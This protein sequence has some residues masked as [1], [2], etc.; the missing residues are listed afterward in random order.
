M[1]N[2]FVAKKKN[3]IKRRLLLKTRLSPT[4]VVT[5][6]YSIFSTYYTTIKW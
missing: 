1:Q 4:H 2:L 5:K 3:Y 6:H